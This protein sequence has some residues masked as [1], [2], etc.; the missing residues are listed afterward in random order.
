LS[1]DHGAAMIIINREPT[2]VDER[3]AVV[4]R[5]DVTEAL[6]QLVEEILGD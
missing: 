4:I 5:A 3:A 6:P 2:F 1:L